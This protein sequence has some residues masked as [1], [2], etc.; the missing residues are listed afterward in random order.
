[1]TLRWLILIFGPLPIVFGSLWLSRWAR[2]EPAEPLAGNDA[3]VRGSASPTPISQSTPQRQTDTSLETACRE[4]ARQLTMRLGAGCEVLVR[5]PFVLGGNLTAKEL[6]D[7]H[8]HT[9]GPASR[10]MGR[11]YFRTPPDRTITVLLFDEADSYNRYAKQLFGE[12]GISVYGYYKPQERTLV[13]NIG[14][15]GGTLV[16]EL[17]HALIAFDFADVPD[18]FNEGLASMHEACHIRKDESGIDGLTNWRLPGLQKAITEKRLPSLEKLLANDDFRGEHVGLN[19][20][21]ARY[22]CLFMQK[23]GVLADFYR[24]FRSDQT[25]DPSGAATVLAV[26]PNYDWKRLDA[27]FAEYVRSLE[28]QR[29]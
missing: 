20:A 24:R 9:I 2:S 14:T 27:E 1:M 18:W 28:W 4:Q 8:D 10:A 6:R 19:Y 13:M 7:W 17:T 26:F 12:E 25:R 21:E 29:R 3:T 5:S 11:A 15:G 22:F 23:R 16:H